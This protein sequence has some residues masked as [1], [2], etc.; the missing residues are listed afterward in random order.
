VIEGQGPQMALFRGLGVQV[1]M[2]LAR[3]LRNSS[4]AINSQQFSKWLADMIFPY[5]SVQYHLPHGSE[6]DILLWPDLGK[7]EYIP[8]K[9]I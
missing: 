9:L 1:R 5:I 2:R 3:S 7:I 8:S 4:L 6:R